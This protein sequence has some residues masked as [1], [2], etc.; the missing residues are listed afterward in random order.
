MTAIARLA[1]SATWGMP[2]IA[3]TLGAVLF[4]ELTLC[5]LLS[6][7]AG[8]QETAGSPLRG[9][10]IAVS[11]G[12][13]AERIPGI[14]S[15]TT[16]LLWSLLGTVV[17]AVASGLEEWQG[18]GDSSVQGGIVFVGVGAL[19][20]GPS[21]GHFYAARPGRALVGIGIR[22]L[23]LAGVA[24]AAAEGLSE[25]GQ[26]TSET[27]GYVSLVLG[28]VAVAWDIIAA[29]HS[30]GVHNDQ[31]RRGRM[32]LGVAPSFGAAGVGLRAEVSF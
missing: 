28:G 23:T 7:P 1:A 12:F 6:G 16:A 4:V 26:H 31:A 29:P 18:S 24:V 30:A 14:K 25:G 3:E 8:A 32:G 13:A 20:I 5:V 10:S 19:V 2:C 27:L 9:D 15:G 11:S 22:T 17:P 21:L